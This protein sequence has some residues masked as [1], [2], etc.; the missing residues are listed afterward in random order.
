M[1]FEKIIKDFD[2]FGIET[3]AIQFNQYGLRAKRTDPKYCRSEELLIASRR[4]RMC[5]EKEKSYA[6]ITGFRKGATFSD[7]RD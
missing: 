6:S 4:E 1:G 5:A 7:P 3:H 2:L